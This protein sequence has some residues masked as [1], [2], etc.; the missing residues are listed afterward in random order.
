MERRLTENPVPDPFIFACGPNAML[1]AAQRFALEKDIPCELSLE[2]EMA[3]GVGICQGCP[4]ERKSGDRKY[5]LVCTDG[6][7]FDARDII[8]REP[9]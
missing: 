8:F 2:S 3:C 4:V 6:P 7:C 1:E 9:A 5:A